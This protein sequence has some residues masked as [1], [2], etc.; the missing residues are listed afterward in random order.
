MRRACALLLT[1]AA[2]G[3][4]SAPIRFTSLHGAGQEQFLADRRECALEARQTVT[5][6]MVNE[7]GKSVGTE[8]ALT[9]AAFNSCL[10]NLGYLRDD[11]GGDLVVPDDDPMPCHR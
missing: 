10:A 7:Y 11:Q 8:D 9:C 1:L 5:S 2:G 3:C 4:A 6:A